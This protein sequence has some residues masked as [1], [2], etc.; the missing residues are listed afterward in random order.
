VTSN[1]LIVEA[2]RRIAEEAPGARVIVFGSF[3]RGDAS[4]GSDL[5]LLVIEP[6]VQ[7][8]A[9]ESVRLRRALCGL[10]SARQSRAR[11]DVRR[12][13]PRRLMAGQ[14]EL[15]AE[16]LELAADDEAAARA[17]I[18]A[19][20]VTESIIGFHAQQ[21]VEKALKAT[22]A[23]RGVEFPFSH[24][25]AR[26]MELCDSAGVPLPSALDDV[27][28]L[29]PYGVRLRYGSAVAG[30]VTPTQAVAWAGDALVWARDV[31]DQS[32]S[33]GS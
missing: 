29:T 9:A 20:S 2:S 26:L 33:P 24:D 5:D 15:A 28:R 18:S 16:L 11:R 32:R 4:E 30:D 19:G 8:A 25:L 3:A 10:P 13:R 12:A 7:N 6:D 23:S 21:T 14:S 31:A 1:E 22:L 17:L 27:D